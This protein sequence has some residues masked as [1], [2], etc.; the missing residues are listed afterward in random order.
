MKV[1]TNTVA[2]I[3]ERKEYTGCL[4]N[5]KTT[6]QYYKVHKVIYNPE[7]EQTVFENAHEPIIDKITRERVQAL[8]KQRK[9]PNRYDEAGLFSG[10]IFC[11]DC[12][13]VMYQQRYQTEK[14]KQDCYICGSYKK[15]TVDCTAHLRQ[16]LLPVSGYCMS[17]SMNL[18]E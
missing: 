15:R 6:M 1:A 5:F 18:P 10:L 4:V 3:L 16:P 7:D 11:A 8:R 12:G 9:R 13:S 14:R 2:H 17:F